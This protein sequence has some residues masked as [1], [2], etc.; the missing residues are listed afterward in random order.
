MISAS[1]FLNPRLFFAAFYC[2]LQGGLLA[3]MY[4][5]VHSF[6]HQGLDSHKFDLTAYYKA[7]CAS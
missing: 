1:M 3:K 5:K 4:Q 7:E 6:D 2:S